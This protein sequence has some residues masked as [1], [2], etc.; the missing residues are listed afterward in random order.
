MITLKNMIQ[1]HLY[2]FSILYLC[3]ILE[4]V[5]RIWYIYIVTLKN[6]PKCYKN[7]Y[8][9]DNRHGSYLENWMNF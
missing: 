8:N 1:L 6:I 5:F 2:L 7:T 4:N 3:K 9:Y